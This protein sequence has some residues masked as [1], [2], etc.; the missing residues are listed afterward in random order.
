[1]NLAARASSAARAGFVLTVAAALFACGS[2][3]N[4]NAGNPCPHLIPAPGADS[5]VLFG[6]GGGH[7]RKDVIIGGKVYSATATCTRESVGLAVNAEIEFYAE[8]A[9]LLVKDTVFP[10]FVALIDPQEHVLVQES[11]QVPIEFH[12]GE[13]YRRTY[14][15]KITIHLPVQNRAAATNYAVVIGFQLTP[16]QL[17][18][19]RSLATRQQ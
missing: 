1:M 17:A 16:D 12:P 7:D 2:T 13:S 3:S 8:R 4:P 19:N 5:I 18:F 10:Y 11:Y 6:P 14:A 15:E 9:N